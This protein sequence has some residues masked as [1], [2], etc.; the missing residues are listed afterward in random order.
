MR[1]LGE[2]GIEDEG[3]FIVGDG[4]PIGSHAVVENPAIGVKR[5]KLRAGGDERVVGGERIPVTSELHQGAAPGS[6]GVE[7]IRRERKC[8]L[9]ARESTGV[10]SVLEELLAFEIRGVAGRAPDDEGLVQE[11]A[12][13]RHAD[14]NRGA[15]EQAVDSLV[16]HRRDRP[17]E[18]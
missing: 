1:P 6:A 5:R 16:T 3:L 17:S 12:A 7:V 15:D 4:L 8:G 9:V 2:L 11:H 13:D 18:G 14:E 10:E